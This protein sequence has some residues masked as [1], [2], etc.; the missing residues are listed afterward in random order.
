LA[1]R[2]SK[3][4]GS[5]GNGVAVGGTGEAVAVGGL[6]V[7]VGVGVLEGGGIGLKVA[8]TV[9]EAVGV[10]GMYAAVSGTTV[11]AG[12]V[13]VLNCPLKAIS[14]ATNNRT[15]AVV[16]PTHPRTGAILGH[17]SNAGRD[18]DVPA[19]V[20]DAGGTTC[21]GG[22]AAPQSLQVSASSGWSRPQDTQNFKKCLFLS[23]S[24]GRLKANLCGLSY[25]TSAFH[26]KCLNRIVFSIWRGGNPARLF[27]FLDALHV[28]CYL[29][30]VN[31]LA[32][33]L[34]IL[35][36]PCSYLHDM[37][38]PLQYFRRFNQ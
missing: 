7:K 10:S 29:L 28:R 21:P 20:S 3:E 37:K 23:G 18:L 27:R 24:S 16:N 5:G 33:I 9:G 6:G 17:L 14:A 25:T 8:V 1:P 12:V 26:Q 22:K 32:N 31:T 36:T 15:T 2:P 11:G 38:E 34:C 19:P 13:C 35:Y 4:I 30:P